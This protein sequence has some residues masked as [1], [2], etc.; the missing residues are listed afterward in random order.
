MDDDDFGQG[1]FD[2]DIDL[3]L[4]VDL[5]QLCRDRLLRLLKNGFRARTASRKRPEPEPKVARAIGLNSLQDADEHD[6]REAVRVLSAWLRSPSEIPEPAQRSGYARPDGVGQLPGPRCVKKALVPQTCGLC[7]EPIKPGDATGRVRPLRPPLHRAFE[8]MGWLCQHC[9]FDRRNTPRRRDVLIRFFHHLLNSSAV[10]LNSHE[11]Q[12]L[13][14]WMNSGPVLESTAWKQDPLD[15]TLIRLATSVAE[16]K[17]NT[18]IAFPTSVTILRAL[19]A[20]DSTD[21]DASL[22]NDVLHHVAEW[23]TNPAGVDH[24]RYGTGV[25]YRQ[26]VLKR[27]TRPTFLSAL[28]GP[29]YLH[30]ANDPAEAAAETETAQD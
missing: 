19:R 6:L 25:A 10:G 21:T 28:G 17:T 13:H 15:A 18:W 14:T 8:P 20:G 5:D 7:N 4:G 1:T 23:E 22:L 11:C 26:Q 2:L 9:L 27:T 30:K 16:D 29:F 24:R 12:V 3:V